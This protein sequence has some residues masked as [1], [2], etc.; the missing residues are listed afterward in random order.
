MAWVK[1]PADEVPPSIVFEVERRDQ[2][3]TIE[4]AYGAH[5]LAKSDIGN[6]QTA[7]YQRVTD[8]SEQ[9][10]FRV[11]YYRRRPVRR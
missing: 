5:P 6:P 2:G 11:S 4:Y 8:L 3:Q 9:P 10:E 1:I 7:P